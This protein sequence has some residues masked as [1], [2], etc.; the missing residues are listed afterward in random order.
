MPPRENEAFPS[1][2]YELLSEP[3]WFATSGGDNPIDSFTVSFQS[4]N[5]EYTYDV[6]GGTY[7]DISL[8][9]ENADCEANQTCAIEDGGW[10]KDI[11]NCVTD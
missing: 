6:E 7:V 1:D 8:C 4:Y 9:S 11:T 5:R 2:E 3:Y 10:C